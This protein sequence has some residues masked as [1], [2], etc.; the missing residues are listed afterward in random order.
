MLEYENFLINQTTEN[1]TK[2][3]NKVNFGK[4]TVHNQP[5]CQFRAVI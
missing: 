3:A 2:S 1:K 5:E 4:L